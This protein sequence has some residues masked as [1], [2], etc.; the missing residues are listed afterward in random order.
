MAAWPRRWFAFVVGLLT[1]LLPDLYVYSSYVL[2]EAPDV[3]FALLYCTLLI[4]ALETLSPSWIVAAA[5]AGSFTV[6]VRS[7]NLV[8]LAIGLAFLLMK[9]LWLRRTAALPSAA[10]EVGQPKPSAKLW[11]F[12][13]AVLIAAVP[14]LAWSAHNAR[15]YG[16]FGISDYGGEILYDGWIYYGESSR[17]AITARIHLQSRRSM[18]P[19]NHDPRWIERPNWLGDLL[20]PARPWLQ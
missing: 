4:S 1:A 17:L 6:L 10:A 8:A 20:F 13:L 19:I 5:L 7:E 14:L 3:F 16:F 15:V 18:Q 12:G 11:H 9:I 2:S